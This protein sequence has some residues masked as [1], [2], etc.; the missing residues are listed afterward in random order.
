MKKILI[1]LLYVSIGIVTGINAN[2]QKQGNEKTWTWTVAHKDTCWKMDDVGQQM[3]LGIQVVAS[4]MYDGYFKLWTK[5][6]QSIDWMPLGLATAGG[7]SINVATLIS[8]G[9]ISGG[10]HYPDPVFTNI[11]VCF[12]H[13]LDTVGTI[14]IYETLIKR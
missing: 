14:K 4:N 2:A 13:K 10:W 9:I 6:E 8:K 12:Y 1:I 5:S 3:A 7:D 11:R